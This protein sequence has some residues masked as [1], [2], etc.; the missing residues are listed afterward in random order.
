MVVGPLD[1]V[2]VVEG[3]TVGAVEVAGEVAPVE[4]G[5]WVVGV[6]GGSLTA[7]DGLAGVPL[8]AAART[9]RIGNN[10]RATLT[11]RRVTGAGDWAAGRIC[12][13]V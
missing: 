11:P 12:H 13:P 6:A 10:R 1:G 7:G 5:G 4:L 3:A 9:R 8:H 2:T